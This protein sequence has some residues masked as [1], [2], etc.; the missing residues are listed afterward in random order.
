MTCATKTSTQLATEVLREMA[1]I[2][3]TETADDY[4]DTRDHLTG[5][6]EIKLNELRSAD[7]GY[8]EDKDKIPDPVFLAVRD[9]VINEVSGS[10]GMPIDPAAKEQRESVIMRRIHRHTARNISGHEK[11]IQYF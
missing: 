3:I 6:Y 1:A 2:D 8:W 10:F 4:A 11:R 7:K 9:L 5:V